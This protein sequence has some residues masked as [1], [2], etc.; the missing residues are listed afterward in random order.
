LPEAARATPSIE[1]PTPEEVSQFL[2]EKA[3]EESPPVPPPPP[4]K[5]KPKKPKADVP[6]PDD[7]VLDA[8]C[9]TCYGTKDAFKMNASMI[10]KCYNDIAKAYAPVTLAQCRVVYAWWNENDWR[11]K[12]GQR[13]TTYQLKEV[14]ATALAASNGGINDSTGTSPF[15]HTGASGGTTEQDVPKESG[16]SQFRRIANEGR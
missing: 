15:N 9:V 12:K 11:G 2:Q 10:R 5:R 8:I 7:G 16:I 4:S 13:P 14:W 1:D 6:P 3:L